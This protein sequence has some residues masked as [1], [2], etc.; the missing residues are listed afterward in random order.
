MNAPSLYRVAI[1]SLVLALL[2]NILLWR[3]SNSDDWF[4]NII[5]FACGAAAVLILAVNFVPSLAR[6]R[7]EGLLVSFA[8][9]T[10]NLVEFALE[11][12]ARWESRVRS[13]AF[14]LAFALLSL[15]AY[16]TQR[17]EREH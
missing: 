6:W 10:A 2:G 16:L 1:I 15:G 4:P 17:Y 7:E 3:V 14:F 12:D 13:G 11:T 9:W 8:L 5:A